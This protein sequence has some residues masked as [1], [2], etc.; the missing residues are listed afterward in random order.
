M[1][2]INYSVATKKSIGCFNV[3]SGD[4]TDYDYTTI[5]LPEGYRRGTQTAG[6]C[7]WVA[8]LHST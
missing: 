1:D 8:S 6:I 5:H 7:L 4:I 2:R 3:I